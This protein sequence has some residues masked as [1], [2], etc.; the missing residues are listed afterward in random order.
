M[1]RI[2]IAKNLKLN[3]TMPVSALQRLSTVATH[4]LEHLGVKAALT[5]VIA[6]DDYVQA[7][8]REH[9]GIDAPTDVLSFAADPL[10]PPIVAEEG[11]DYLGDLI[12]AYH[13]TLSQAQAANHN[14]ADEFALLVVHGILH[15]V[16]YDHDSPATQQVMWAKQAELLEMLGI[17]LT[18]PDFIHSSDDYNAS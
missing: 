6:T 3:N 1:I 17:G 5:I 7:L 10:P 8:N 15:L 18:V 9:R 4:I 16:G 14:P 13:H 12:L 2:Q 11:N